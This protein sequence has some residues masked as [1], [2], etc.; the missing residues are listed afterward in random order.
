M[1]SRAYAEA[2]SV[3]EAPAPSTAS[4]FGS[5]SNAHASSVPITRPP[6]CVPG[7]GLATEPVARMIA[8]AE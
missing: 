6:N 7:T 5:S 4:V 1:P 3:P 8:F 2:I